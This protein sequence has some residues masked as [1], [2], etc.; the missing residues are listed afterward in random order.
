MDGVFQC[1]SAGRAVV[2]PGAFGAP[3]RGYGA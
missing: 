3:L 2:K 1:P